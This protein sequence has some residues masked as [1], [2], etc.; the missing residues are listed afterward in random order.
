[1]VALC[2]AYADE[3]AASFFAAVDG[4]ASPCAPSGYFA[5]GAL[6]Y[7]GV[8]MIFALR[9][10]G[11]LTLPH[12]PTPTTRKL[13]QRTPFSSLSVARTIA[14][15]TSTR[16]RL[17]AFPPSGLLTFPN[18]YLRAW[19][20]VALLG[21]ASCCYT[22]PLEPLLQNCFCFS[23]LHV[24]YAEPKKSPACRCRFVVLV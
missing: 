21:F 6:G 9:L 10:H 20:L 1:M 14:R 5:V 23:R 19:L 15:F 24:F 16:F 11:V 12:L 4:P 17:K 3:V 22:L 13:S 8:T 2:W 7:H 18:C